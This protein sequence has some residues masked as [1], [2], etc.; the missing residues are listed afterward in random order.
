MDG[1]PQPADMTYSGDS[2]SPGSP[3][4]AGSALADRDGVLRDLSRYLAAAWASFDGPRPSEPG[5]DPELIERLGAGLPEQRSDP[6]AA[7]GDAVRILDASVSPSR[8]L[9]L[10]YIGSSGLEVGVLAAALSAAYDVNL[11]T[12]AAPPAC[13]ISR[14]CA[15][16]RTS[17]AF[18][19]G[20]ATSPA[21]GR[22]PT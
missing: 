22:R 11:A 2:I 18:R 3:D 6:Q 9:Y 19:S 1:R 17:W 12:A 21:A 15:G 5:A 8:P 4:A 7:L 20:R 16:W 13:S 14:P 10:A